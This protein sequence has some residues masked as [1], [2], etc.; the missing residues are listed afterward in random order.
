VHFEESLVSYEHV[1]SSI[2]QLQSA[3][4]QQVINMKIADSPASAIESVG[5]KDRGV[6]AMFAKVVDEGDH[7]VEEMAQSKNEV[8]E[9]HGLWSKLVE[10]ELDGEGDFER[11]K[12]CNCH[13]PHETGR[14]HVSR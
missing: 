11:A 7:V 10:D 9:L 3:Y 13:S 5:S 2:Q 4:G 14:Q 12:E 1:F 8:K 6:L